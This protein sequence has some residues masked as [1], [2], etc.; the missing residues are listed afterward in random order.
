MTEKS[1]LINEL[2]S[3]LNSGVQFSDIRLETSAP[4]MI[5]T[6][7]GWIEADI[8]DYPT[9]DDIGCFLAA[10]EPEWDRLLEDGAINRPL[11]LQV[12]RLRINA[13]LAYGGQKLMASIRRIPVDPPSIQ[14]VGLPASTRLLLENTSG[15]IL[16]SGPTGAGKTTS[17][18]ALV[19]EINNTRN[20]HILSIEDPIE[21]L[22]KR[23]QSVFSQREIGVDCDSFFDG[24]KDALRQR[25]DVI[26][27]GEIRD[28]ATAEQALI[29]GESGHLVIG[30]L[31]ASSAISTI[32]KILGFFNADER[33]SKEQSLAGNLVGVINQTL[34]P[35]KDDDGYALAI[36]FLA[37]HKREFSKIIREPDKMQSMLDRSEEEKSISIGFGSSIVKLISD[38]IVDK[39]TAIKFASSNAAVYEKIKNA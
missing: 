29:A 27:I 7:K 21:F 17:M 6:S 38:G 4:I 1:S 32:S 24:V 35:R 18:A 31:H 22:H 16:I 11:D 19:D 26:V 23:K 10:I 12:W 25:P 2:L 9:Y 15:I 37:N 30:T 33:E 8:L 39:N 20:A 3:L 34:I 13:Y 28:K 36:D 14:N 5:K